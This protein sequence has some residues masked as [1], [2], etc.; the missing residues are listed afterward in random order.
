MA[1]DGSRIVEEVGVRM[2]VKGL[3]VVSSGWWRCIRGDGMGGRW[4]Y[5]CELRVTSKCVSGSVFL[6]RGCNSG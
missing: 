1:G 6:L 2:F 4:I 5:D 3:G